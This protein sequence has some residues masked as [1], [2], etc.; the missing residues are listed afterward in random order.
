MA[1]RAPS[2]NL[3]WPIDNRP[4]PLPGSELPIL[5]GV[6]QMSFGERAALEGMLCQL[7]PRLAIEIGRAEGASLERIALHSGEVHS[8]DVEPPMERSLELE[9]AH[10]H[11]GDS[12][13]LL[14][15]LLADLAEQGR[16]VDFALVDGD[17]TAA[18][19][20]RDVENLLSS[21]AV[22]HTI[23][24]AHDTTNQEVRA[25]FEGV[26]YGHL[27][28]VAYADVDFVPGYIFRS[29][30]FRNELW[31]GFGLIVVGGD[32]TAGNGEPILQNLYH[33]A[34]RILRAVGEAIRLS[35]EA[36][37][38]RADGDAAD[39]GALAL[40]GLEQRR[41]EAEQ[42]AMDAERRALAA[43]RTQRKAEQTLR[44]V[45][46]S[47]SWRVTAPLRAATRVLRRR[48]SSLP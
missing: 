14:P 28:K 13:E 48:P 30:A 36:G 17:H 26:P 37:A 44:R 4:A 1:E 20:R 15:R 5:S 34:H 12:G 35:D 3:P 29:G 33:D 25:G 16:N 32:R 22:G 40:E 18:G 43:E 41:R 8:I 27:A 21:P 7:Q 45:V 42:R 11:V 9:N 23:I 47:R 46:G 2:E 19:V 6:C 10:L 39:I 24:L 38:P 31:G